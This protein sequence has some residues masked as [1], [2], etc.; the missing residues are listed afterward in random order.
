MK[1]FAEQR[2]EVRLASVPI[3]DSKGVGVSGRLEFKKKSF[4]PVFTAVYIIKLLV[5][6]V[7]QN[8]RLG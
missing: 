7:A 2:T 6:T 8:L 3:A 4:T 1:T 5:E